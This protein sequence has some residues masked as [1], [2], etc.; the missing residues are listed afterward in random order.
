MIPPKNILKTIE[1]DTPLETRNRTLAETPSRSVRR[2]SALPSD[3][4]KH[5]AKI[6]MIRYSSVN[7]TRI[8]GSFP[9]VG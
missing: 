5:Q 4:F 2:K 3:Y 6:N 9:Y 8:L 1:V 7:A